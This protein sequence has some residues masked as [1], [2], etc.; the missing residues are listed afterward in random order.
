MYLGVNF[1]GTKARGT[2]VYHFLPWDDIASLY[3]FVSIVGGGII[4]YNILV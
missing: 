2:P 3:I 1:I 4:M